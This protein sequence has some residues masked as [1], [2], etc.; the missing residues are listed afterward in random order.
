MIYEVEEES[1]Q[2]KLNALAGKAT[3]GIPLGTW[4][5]FENDSAPNIE[6]IRAGTTFD[7]N[8]YPALAMYLG[9]DKVPE[10]FDHSRLGEYENITLSTSSSSPTIV[11]YDG[12][13][14]LNSTQGDGGSYRL[15]SIFINGIQINTIQ[16]ANSRNI[17]TVTI[18]IKKGDSIYLGDNASY[19][20]IKVRYYKHP[21][22]IKATPTS[23][24]S[25]YEGTL[26]AVRQYV[27]NSNSYSTEEVWTGGYWIDGKK[28]YRRVVEF[29][30]T[31]SIYQQWGNLLTIENVNQVISASVMEYRSGEKWVVPCI[32]RYINGT[33]QGQSNNGGL[34]STSAILEYTKTTD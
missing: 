1:G 34:Y 24:N 7:V 18:P 29:A 4:L 26:N 22:F 28:I 30:S 3:T 27:T 2:K 6:W 12:F 31:V 16:Y 14:I 15:G 32:G 11:E 10:R 20:L 8:A 19:T 13:I 9:S 25:D 5:S 33:I 17:N 23:S 21:M